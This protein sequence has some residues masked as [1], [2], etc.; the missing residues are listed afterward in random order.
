MALAVL[1]VMY[2]S[3]GKHQSFFGPVNMGLCRGGNLLLGLSV[4][5][6]ALQDLWWIALLPVIYI[7]AIT[8]ISRGEV[9]GGS[10]KAIVAGALMYAVI[11]IALIVLA[12]LSIIPWWQA[13]PFVLLFS[14]LIFRPLINALEKQEPQLIGK[15]VKAGVLSLIVFDATLATV[16]A[17][18]IYGLMVLILLPVSMVIAK[19]SSV[20]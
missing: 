11:I 12:F 8:M 18:W 20:T 2:N 15:A 9:H 4:I 17:G 19:K 10:R 14:F 1:A 6:A 7:A 3:W 16:F 5:P 13:V